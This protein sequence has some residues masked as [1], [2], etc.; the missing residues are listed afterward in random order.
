M[1]SRMERG[2]WSSALEAVFGIVWG[3]F[4]GSSRGDNLKRSTAEWL[5]EWAVA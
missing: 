5:F 4:S 3:E 1:L 2:R